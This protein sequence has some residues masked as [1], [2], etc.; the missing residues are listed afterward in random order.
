MVSVTLVAT[1]VGT[2]DRSALTVQVELSPRAMVERPTMESSPSEIAAAVARKIEVRAL[3][4]GDPR[5]L[6]I[7]GRP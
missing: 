2:V 7:R 3:I 4:S 6:V 1:P 5:L